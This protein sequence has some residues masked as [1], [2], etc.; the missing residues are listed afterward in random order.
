MLFGI[1]AQPMREGVLPQLFGHVPIADETV[2][3]W[4]HQWRMVSSNKKRFGSNVAC[5]ASWWASFWYLLHHH[6]VSINTGL[7]LSGTMLLSARVV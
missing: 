2:G 7:F 4:R 1:D 3:Q 6:L 5:L